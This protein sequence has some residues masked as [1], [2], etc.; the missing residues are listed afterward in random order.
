MVAAGL[1]AAYS[2][3]KFEI[4]RTPPEVKELSSPRKMSVNSIN[5]FGKWKNHV[6][7]NT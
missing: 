6:I 2:Q 3:P 5:F 1:E 4:L 7:L